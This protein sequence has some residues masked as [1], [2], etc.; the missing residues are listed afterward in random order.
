M[1]TLQLPLQGEGGEKQD[2]ETAD[3][4]DLECNQIT[5]N[6]R[7]SQVRLTGLQ[8]IATVW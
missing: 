7:Y 6:G 8:R 5:T 2:E 3:Q 1:K 4:S